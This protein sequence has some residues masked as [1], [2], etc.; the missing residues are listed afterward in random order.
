[1]NN[2]TDNMLLNTLP[3]ESKARIF[4]QLKPVHLPLG[5]VIY[6]SGQSI[7]LVYF[8]TDRKQRLVKFLLDMADKN[9]Q[10]S[11]PYPIVNLSMTRGDIANYLGM[12][13]ET[14]SRLLSKID[15]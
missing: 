11:E 9:K 2:M 6:E 15:V 5:E 14:I 10:S 3:D 8:P 4:P 1:M 13:I 7:G 12:A